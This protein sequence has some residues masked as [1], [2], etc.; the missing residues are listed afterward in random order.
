MSNTSKCCYCKTNLQEF[1]VFLGDE[2]RLSTLYESC[3]SQCLSTVVKNAIVQG[4]KDAEEQIKRDEDRL[5]KES[6]KVVRES[7]LK[8]LEKC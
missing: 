4:Q 6:L 5:L 2:Q 8:N 1:S 3:C 7:K